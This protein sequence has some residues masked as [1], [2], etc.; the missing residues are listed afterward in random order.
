M[1]DAETMVSYIQYV[2]YVVQ[3]ILLVPV[4]ASAAAVRSSRCLRA[5]H[6]MEAIR[7]VV[8]AMFALVVFST[9]YSQHVAAQPSC[10]AAACLQSVK[11]GAFDTA[12]G[13]ATDLIQSVPE[14]PDAWQCLG[15]AQYS[16]G[17]LHAAHASFSK[18]RGSVSRVCVVPS[19]TSASAGRLRWCSLTPLQHTAGAT[20]VC[21]CTTWG[22]S[23]L[24]LMPSG[25]P[26]S[27]TSPS[28][29]HS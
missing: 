18:V 2:F 27:W 29:W 4:Q 12:V 21:H 13:A 17:E 19:V 5:G 14:C 16:K 24:P 8:V 28:V 6:S 22:I 25:P 10:N 1:H 23:P 9:C 26:F 15:A 11:H 20:L 7:G 3:A